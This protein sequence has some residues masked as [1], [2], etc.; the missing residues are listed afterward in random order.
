MKKMAARDFEDLLLVRHAPLM[1]R[2]LLTTLILQCSIPVFEDLLVDP[3]DNAMVLDLLF[4]AS[5]WHGLAKMRIH[6]D[7]TLKTFSLVTTQLG[8]ALRQFTDEVC[9]KYPTKDSVREARARQKKSNTPGGAVRKDRTFNLKTYKVH[10][11]GDYPR[12]IPLF[13]TTDGYS[14]QIVSSRVFRFRVIS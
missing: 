3:L 4:I 8:D 10:A 6:T 2:P 11:L 13:G 14:T 9:P 1:C 12:T 7:S 5:H